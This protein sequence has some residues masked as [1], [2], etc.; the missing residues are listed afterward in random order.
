MSQRIED[1]DKN[2]KSTPVKTA[3]N[4]VWH[5]QYGAVRSGQLGVI[6]GERRRVLPVVEGPRLGC[7]DVSGW[8]TN[9][10]NDIS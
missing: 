6:Q 7:S 5:G 9:I 1:L 8:L 10:I 3:D 2:F 4:I